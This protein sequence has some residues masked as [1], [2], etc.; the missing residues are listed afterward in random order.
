V[1]ALVSEGLTN[2]EIARRLYVSRH[3][4]VSHLKHVYSKL[5]LTSRVELAAEVARRA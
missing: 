3:T 4:V 1:V 2:P 5:G